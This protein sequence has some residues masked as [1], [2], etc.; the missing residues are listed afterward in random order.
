MSQNKRRTKDKT[1]YW[2]IDVS[3]MCEKPSCVVN[4]ATFCLIP[5]G[6]F[7]HYSIITYCLVWGTSPVLE[8]GLFKN[9][10]IIHLIPG[11]RYNI[12]RYFFVRLISINIH[13]STYFPASLNFNECDDNDCRPKDSIVKQSKVNTEVLELIILS[14]V[15]FKCKPD[16]PSESNLHCNY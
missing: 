11:M 9:G 4:T 13:H 10:F 6:F 3:L 15:L 1:E 2:I 12:S 8:I 16:S 7:N 5:S 14:N